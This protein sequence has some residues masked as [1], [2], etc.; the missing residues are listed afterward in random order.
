MVL[1]QHARFVKSIGKNHDYTIS[2]VRILTVSLTTLRSSITVVKYPFTIRFYLKCSRTSF[3]Y[4]KHR[5][6][7]FQPYR[8]PFVFA[9]WTQIGTTNI[10]YHRWCFELQNKSSSYYQFAK[11]YL[12]YNKHRI[13]FISHNIKMMN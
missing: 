4:Q 5:L 11:S 8:L 9:E 7:K 2:R 1:E 10:K 3:T 13:I 12:I 6:G